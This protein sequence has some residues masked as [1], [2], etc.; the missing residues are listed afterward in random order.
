MKHT[1]CLHFKK[2][3]FSFAYVF[4]LKSVQFK[5]RVFGSKH[6]ECV[7]DWVEWKTVVATINIHLDTKTSKTGYVP[8]WCVFE[9]CFEN[10][11]AYRITGNLLIKHKQ[12]LKQ[13][14]VCPL[15]KTFVIQHIII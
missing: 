14:W 5:K 13:F 4:K 6:P 7:A 8:I 1:D 12:F 11:F 3:R 15:K 2:R 9:I 10:L